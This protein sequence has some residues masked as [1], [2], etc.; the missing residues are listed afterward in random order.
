MM[1]GAWAAALVSLL[2]AGKLLLNAFV[3]ATR[4]A[5]HEEFAKVWDDMAEQKRVNDA[6]FERLEEAIAELKR[7]IARLE[8]MMLAHMEKK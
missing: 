6:R 1:W 7:Q 2:T 4:A 3:K 5:V 8:A